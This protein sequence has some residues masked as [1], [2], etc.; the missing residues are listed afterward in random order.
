MDGVG[1]GFLGVIALSSLVQAA[2]L[3]GLALSAR[4]LGRRVEEIQQRVDRDLRPTLESLSRISR[5]LAEVS[6]TA[7]IQAR[8][9][10]EL[11]ADTVEKIEETTSMVRSFVVRPLGPLSDILAFLRGVRRGVE[12]YSQFKGHDSAVRGTRRRYT[13]DEH[14]F[15]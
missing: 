5:N 15:I 14:L 4:R 8:R 12:V 3:I 7:V 9:V 11:I 6:D 13:E 2:F 10:D 1:V